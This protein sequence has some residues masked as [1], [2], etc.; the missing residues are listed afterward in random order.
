MNA[1]ELTHA[2]RGRWRGQHGSIRCPCHQDRTPSATVRD[3]DQPGRLLFVCF[4]GCRS[5]D[6]VHELRRSGL[7]DKP[8][9]IGQRRIVSR[10]IEHKPDPAALALWNSSSPAAGTIVERYLRGRGI[11]LPIPLSIRCTAG[12]YMIAAIQAPAG[13]VIAVQVTALTKGATRAQTAIPRVTTGSMGYG[14]VRLA[15]A[16][17]LLG[18]AE[19]VETALSAMQI[20]GI[21]CLACIGAARMHRVVIPPS[22][23]EL[24]IFGD[25]DEAGHAAAERTAGVH[26]KRNVQLRYPPNDHKDWNDFLQAGGTL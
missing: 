23:R 6:I 3:G 22:I 8:E 26:A 7:L 25:N 10:P 20:T 9:R 18:I 17:D 4:A 15:K 11:T 19:G 21:P 2:M 12:G 13:D 1:R 24:H 14:A 16:E 5:S